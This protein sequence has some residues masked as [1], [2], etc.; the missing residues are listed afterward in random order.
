MSGIPEQTSHR[1]YARNAK[2][3]I[4]IKKG[5]KR[6]KMSEILVINIWKKGS[7]QYT[8]RPDY[9]IEVDQG[10]IN[11]ISNLV[12]AIEEIAKAI[13]DVKK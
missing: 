6:A 7:D 5:G 9:H 3:H 4:G 8:T 10:E 2:A 12:Y 13:K 1:K 11:H